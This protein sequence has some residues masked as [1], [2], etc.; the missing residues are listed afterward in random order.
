MRDLAPIVIFAWRRPKLFY[1]TLLSLSKCDLFDKSHV[2][3]FIDG[4]RNPDDQTKISETI[5]IAE[6]IR[7]EKLEIYK[8]EENLGLK[9]NIKDGISKIIS[10]YG[11][12]IVIEEDMIFSK[13]FLIF[14]NK[15]LN[16][17]S[18]S[19]DVFS[20]TGYSPPIRIPDDYPYSVFFFFRTSSWGW[21]TWGRVWN[22]FESLKIS[23]HDIKSLLNDPVELNKFCA[24]GYDL[25]DIIVKAFGKSWSIEFD[26]YCYKNSALCLYPTRTKLK[27][28][29]FREGENVGFQRLK[30]I[31]FPFDQ[32]SFQESY[33]YPKKPFVDWRIFCEFHRYINEITKPPSFYEK[34]LFY[35]TE[36]PFRPKFVLKKVFDKMFRSFKA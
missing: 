28:I 4:P 25:K 24:G 22:E 34:I 9:K 19:P 27:H 10:K 26:Y 13:D 18:D 36:F 8:R 31:D 29:G 32:Q 21:G 11:K 6:N 7:S 20:I 3:I 2:F 23:E 14:M 12:A 16:E 5:K 35:F 30:L 1:Q 17:Y 15:F 33:F